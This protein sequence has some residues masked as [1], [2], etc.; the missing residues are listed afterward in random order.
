VVRGVASLVSGTLP[1]L[2]AKERA[3]V[4]SGKVEVTDVKGAAV[5][6]S[7]T[8]ERNWKGLYRPLAK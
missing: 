8:G 4:M 7:D 3:A 5:E 2:S 1:A 6:G